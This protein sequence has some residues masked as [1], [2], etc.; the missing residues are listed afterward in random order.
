MERFQFLFQLAGHFRS[1][2]VFLQNYG[3][4]LAIPGLALSLLNCFFGFRLRKFWS[5]AAGFLA[6]AAA[7][8]W[9]CLHFDL[10][11][12]A[13]T[14]LAAL[15]G[16]LLCGAAAFLLY[17]AGLFLLCSGLTVFV[18]VRLLRPETAAA[19]WICL[20]SGILVG[21]LALLRE[22]LTV[23]LATAIGGGW[24]SAEF[25]LVLTGMDSPF[26]LLL[27]TLLFAFLGILV[28]LKPWKPKEY[29][30][31]QDQK[32][33]KKEKKAG[34]GRRRRRRIR[35]SKKK[36][37]KN[38]RKQKPARQKKA[39]DHADR[40]DRVDR[41]GPVDRADRADRAPAPAAGTADPDLS[42]V[43]QELS[44]EVS[45]IYR[46]EQEN[47]LSQ[48]HPLSGWLVLPL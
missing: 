39:A 42:A 19:L 48:D 16:G 24:G 11:S 18:A 47:S 5:A 3:T 23:S 17:R 35:R 32:L 43:R 44:Q 29:W 1:L 37:R 26:L 22:R 13:L 30:D 8:L 9:I 40:A 4:L 31:E 6:G 46:Q 36:P 41:T 38:A 27:L 21:I 7:G 34:K 25:L 15:A 33:R 2:G 14:L 28:Q 10:S 45:E 12:A 20:L